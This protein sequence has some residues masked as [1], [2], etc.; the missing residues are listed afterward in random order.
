MQDLKIYKIPLL[1]LEFKF[2]KTH[3]KGISKN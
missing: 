3:F 2:E 1:P